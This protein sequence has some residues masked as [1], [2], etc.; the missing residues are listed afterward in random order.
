MN[1]LS[2]YT[3]RVAQSAWGEPSGVWS[4]VESWGVRGHLHRW[5][6]ETK[7][8][9]KPPIQWRM[10]EEAL[11][12]FTC[13]GLLLCPWSHNAGRPWAIIPLPLGFFKVEE[14]G[15]ENLFQIQHCGMLTMLATHLSPPY[16]PLQ[17]QL[18][19]EQSPQ[20]P[21]SLPTP[22]RICISRGKGIM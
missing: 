15:C 9:S 18:K 17:P 11:A 16:R 12:W 19:L 3:P 1:R 22:W 4:L 7:L 10:T 21:S 6:M 20:G 8:V 5:P 14:N 13:F 2:I